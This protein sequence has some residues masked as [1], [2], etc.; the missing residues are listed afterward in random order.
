MKTDLLEDLIDSQDIKRQ[1]EE[2]E[3][4]KEEMATREF[5]KG[6]KKESGNKSGA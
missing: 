2:Q 4:S 1:K 5:G 3:Y 6:L